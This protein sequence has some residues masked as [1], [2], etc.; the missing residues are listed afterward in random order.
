V[1]S[2][3]RSPAAYGAPRRFPAFDQY[4]SRAHLFSSLPACW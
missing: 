4:N 1:T 3:Q 2:S